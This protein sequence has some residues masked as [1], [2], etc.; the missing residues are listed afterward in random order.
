PFSDY[1]SY[2][3]SI[4]VQTLGELAMVSSEQNPVMI[5]AVVS[6]AGLIV[7]VSMVFGFIIWRR[8]VLTMAT[9]LGLGMNVLFV[10][11]KIPSRRTYIDPET[12]EDPV[13]A[14]HLF[15]KELDL[16]CIKIER[17]IG[18]D[19]SLSPHPPPTPK[20]GV[21]FDICVTVSCRGVW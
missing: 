16:S 15:A 12:C 5:I 11:V 17:V 9:C 13:Q 8:C 20:A 6:V 14:V 19:V 2:S 18:G 10:S 7:L 21:P 3:S 4:E 1:G